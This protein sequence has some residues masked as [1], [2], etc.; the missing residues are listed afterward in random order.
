MEEWE[1]CVECLRAGEEG[2]GNVYVPFLCSGLVWLRPT[3]TKVENKISKEK[4]H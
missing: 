3:V 1:C 4:K 2:S